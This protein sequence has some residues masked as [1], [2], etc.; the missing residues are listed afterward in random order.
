M[1]DES[2]KKF[3]ELRDR[4]FYLIHKELDEDPY[5]KSYEGLY[6]ICYQF[7]DYFEEYT[8]EPELVCITLHC[9]LLGSG[10]HH[11]FKGKT[12]E[13]ALEKLENQIEEWETT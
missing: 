11:Y 6:E 4:T 1:N 5:C 2:Y 9:Y 7:G 8:Q 13:E 10:R 3:L 12:F